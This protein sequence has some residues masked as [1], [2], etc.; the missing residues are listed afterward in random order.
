LSKNYFKVMENTGNITGA[1][2]QSLK[3]Q[4][5]EVGIS[6]SRLC[7]EAGVDR[8][9]IERWKHKD[10]NTIEILNALKDV[11]DRKRKQL[12]SHNE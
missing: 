4:C 3:E 12:K 10:P 11:L 9:T 1:T 7:R 8:G 2:Y 5:E 6:M